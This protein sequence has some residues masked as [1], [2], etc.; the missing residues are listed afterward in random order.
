[1]NSATAWRTRRR[2]LRECLLVAG[3]CEGS[4]LRSVDFPGLPGRLLTHVDRLFGFVVG[5]RA[6]CHACGAAGAVEQ[7][8]AFR[9]V[10]EVFLPRPEDQDRVWTTTELCYL[11]SIDREVSSRLECSRCGGSTVHRSQLRVVTAPNV[12]LI[13]PGRMAFA[14][15]GR[16]VAYPVQ[17]ERELTL[18]GLGD[19]Y[20]LTGVVYRRGVRAETAKYHC[21]VKCDDGRWWRFE[22]GCLPRVFRG[23]LER[24][25]LRAI[26]LLVYTRPRAQARFV[27]MAPLAPSRVAPPAAQ[28]VACLEAAVGAQTGIA[29]GALAASCEAPAAEAP[30]GGGVSCWRAEVFEARSCAAFARA[31]LLRSG[32]VPI[33]AG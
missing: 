5:Q 19:R 33:L 2:S 16:V 32:H 12:L 27:D 29:S 14:Q 1:M 23:D 22:D 25:E 8:F 7:R 17:P 4:Q 30:S 31:V 20:E 15:S 9:H 21:V 26:H 13:E 24:S 11:V 18:P 10:L 6:G 28:A 3:G